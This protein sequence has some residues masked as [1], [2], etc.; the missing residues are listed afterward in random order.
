M[1]MLRSTSLSLTSYITEALVETI[2]LDKGVCKGNLYASFW[3]LTLIGCYILHLV[4]LHYTFTHTKQL[5][6]EVKKFQS[7]PP[8]FVK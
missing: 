6:P 2:S 1:A 5:V 4:Q 7:L 3:Y 8:K